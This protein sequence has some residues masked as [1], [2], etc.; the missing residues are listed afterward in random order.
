MTNANPLKIYHEEIRQHRDL[1]FIPS[2]YIY[3]CISSLL[4]VQCMDWTLQHHLSFKIPWCPCQNQ[5]RLRT[6][7]T[8][9][10]WKNQCIRCPFSRSSVWPHQPVCVSSPFLPPHCML[11]PVSSKAHI[12]S[13]FF[14]SNVKKFTLA[15]FG[16]YYLCLQAF[17]HR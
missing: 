12:P 17:Q 16:S 8:L 4:K 10:Q 3:I 15:G 14:P 6:D 2:I 9:K 1:D 5:H 7:M 11:S 13:D